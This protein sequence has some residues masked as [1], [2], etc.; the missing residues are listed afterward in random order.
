MPI[1]SCMKLFSKNHVKLFETSGDI[2]DK[3]K[4]SVAISSS[5][6]GREGAL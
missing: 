1:L 6:V 2:T 5:R 3:N 4:C